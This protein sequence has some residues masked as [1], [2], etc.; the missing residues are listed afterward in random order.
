M[1]ESTASRGRVRNVVIV[2]DSADNFGGTAQVAYV[3]ARVLTDRGY[4]VVYFAGSGPVHNRLDG[5]RVICVHKLPA[6]QNQSKVKGAIQGLW[7]RKTYQAMLSLLSEFNPLDTV[8]HVHSWTHT[9][10]SSVFSAIAKAGF[11]TLFTLH[12]YFLTCPNG[13]FYDYQANEICS[14]KP[15]SIACVCRNCDKRSYAQ[16]LYRLLRISIQTRQIAKV[17]CKRF[18]YLS[19]FTYG[20]LKGNHFDD[21]QPMFLPNPI[22]VEPD[23]EPLPSAERRGYLYV[24]RFDSEKNPGLFCRALTYMGL[25]G[26]LCGDG[27]QLARLRDEYPNLEFLGWC[28]KTALARQYRSKRT[29]VLTSSCFEAS[30]LGCLEAMLTSGIPSIVP[31]TCGATAYIEDGVN[32]LYFKN[33]DE[34]S[35][36]AALARMEDEGYYEKL[37]MNVEHELPTILEDRSYETYAERV[38]AQYEGL[39]E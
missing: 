27:P 3:T 38:I 12:D 2:D 1:I 15:C 25:P 8:V 28:D 10:S 26:T 33:N 37:C 29:F 20:I 34:D 31:E 24:G 22:S 36:C 4:N 18:C 9:L 14:L 23:S 21:G 30:P 16:K 35:L 6:L 17:R 19:P 11:P 5:I 13:G 7:S 32:G 39:Y